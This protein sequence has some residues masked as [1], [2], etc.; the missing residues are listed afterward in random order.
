MPTPN[1]M[2]SLSRDGNLHELHLDS[3]GLPC[4]PEDDTHNGQDEKENSM[5]L[6]ES[7]MNEYLESHSETQDTDKAC[8][9]IEI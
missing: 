3:K 9:T 6:G 8:E 7:A 4:Y 1:R 5:S 2:P